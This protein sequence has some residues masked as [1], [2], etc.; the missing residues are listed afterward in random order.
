MA[1]IARPR[2]KVQLAK[3]VEVVWDSF[4][5]GVNKLLQDVE[6]TDEEYRRGDNLILKGAGI[7]TTRPGT[8]NYYQAG[9]SRV[10]SL[11]SYYMKSGTKE[12]LA[13]TDSGYLTKK[14]STSYTIIPGGSYTSGT[15]VTM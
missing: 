3:P 6:L 8:A 9:G 15:N 4:R 2:G 14:N 10:R 1:T 7:I 11:K 13:L 12:L 5:R